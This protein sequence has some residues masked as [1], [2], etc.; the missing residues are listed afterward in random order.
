MGEIMNKE[1]QRI[2]IAEACG[3]KKGNVLWLSFD[4]WEKN[5]I[6]HALERVELADWT[7][8]ALPDYLN[9]LN[10][11]HEA[12]KIL[13]A[14]QCETFNHIL[15]HQ[16][17]DTSLVCS[18]WAWHATASE[19]AEAFLKTLGLWEVLTAYENPTKSKEIG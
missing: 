8:L 4:I 19:R 10:A 17:A 5:H 18:S 9:D 1:K 15:H 3:Y 13:T 7:Y 11:I 2:T 6:Q 16:K 12:E 14:D